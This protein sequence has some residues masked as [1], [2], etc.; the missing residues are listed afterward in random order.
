MRSIEDL[1]NRIE[2]KFEGIE[3]LLETSEDDSAAD[4][5][6]DD[7]EAG[8]VTAVEVTLTASVEAAS[9]PEEVSDPV[10]LADELDAS[11][12]GEDAASDFVAS[13]ADDDWVVDVTRPRMEARGASE[14]VVADAD[15][16]VVSCTAAAVV[17]VVSSAADEDDSAT[18]A[19]VEVS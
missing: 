1:K 13:E 3:D 15:S 16:D 10:P 9:E 8:S 6:V 19:E 7:V 18:V 11:E 5:P 14:E 12:E 2:D 17:E 4:E